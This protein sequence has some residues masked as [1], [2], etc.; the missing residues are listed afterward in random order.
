MSGKRGFTGA[1]MPQ[2][3]NKLT[4]F[5]FK[6][7]IVDSSFHS[8]HIIFSIPPDVIKLNMLCTNQ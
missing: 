7:D 4:R 8:Y 2:Y 3:C 5:H 1:I 6:G